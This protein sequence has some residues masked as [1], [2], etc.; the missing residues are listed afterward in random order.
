MK[1]L[2]FITLCFLSATNIFAQANKK[3]V[4]YMLEV[5]GT[6]AKYQEVVDQFSEQIPEAL[7]GQ[8]K[9]DIQFFIDKQIDIEV[10]KYAAAFSQDEILKIIEFYK[11][12]LGIKLLKES[13]TIN[14]AMLLGIE[15]NQSELQGIILKYFR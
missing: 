2:L 5:S 10:E 12:P 6:T 4:K 14:E 11:S 15:N 9:K 8:F 13:N 3:D 7:R 1:K